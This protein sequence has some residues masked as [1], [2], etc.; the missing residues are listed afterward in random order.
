[1]N[2]GVSF[3]TNVHPLEFL[4]SPVLL[5]SYT[6]DRDGTHISTRQWH[7]NIASFSS[8]KYCNTN[9]LGVLDHCCCLASS[10]CGTRLCLYVAAWL[11]SPSMLGLRNTVGDLGCQLCAGRKRWKMGID[12]RTQCRGS[13]ETREHRDMRM[14]I[15]ERL[16]TGAEGW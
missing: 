16:S 10:I 15:Y 2:D 7:D 11:L 5:V 1:M 13:K 12:T 6:S 8:R 3:V 9:I 14:G 4:H